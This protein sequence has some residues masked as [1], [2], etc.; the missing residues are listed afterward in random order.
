VVAVNFPEHAV[1]GD[2]RNIPRQIRLFPFSLALGLNYYAMLCIHSGLRK[3]FVTRPK[4]Q[5]HE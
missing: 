3:Q 4:K 1:D 2:G 5:A